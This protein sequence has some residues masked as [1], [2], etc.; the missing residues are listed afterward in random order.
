RHFGIEAEQVESEDLV[1]T[2]VEWAERNDIETIFT[3]R[4]FVGVLAESWGRMEDK[5]GKKNVELMSLRRSKD[6]MAMNRATAGFFGFWKKTGI[7]REG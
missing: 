6:V 7:L 4:P 3:M 2:M 1:Q 5:L